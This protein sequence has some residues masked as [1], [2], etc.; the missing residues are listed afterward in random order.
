MNAVAKRL[1]PKR[2]LLHPVPR[3][4]NEIS[5]GDQKGRPARPQAK[6]TP[7]V[8]PLGYIEDAGETRTK[9]AALF[10]HPSNNNGTWQE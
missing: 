7:Q 3:R 1:K 2:L 10:H 5:Q 6:P 8:Y 9:L 4:A